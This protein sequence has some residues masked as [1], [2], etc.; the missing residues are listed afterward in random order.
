[1]STIRSSSSSMT[2]ING[3][4]QSLLD[5]Q[6]AK[7]TAQLN[8]VLSSL[9]QQDKD[10]II[11]PKLSRES[12][13]RTLMSDVQKCQNPL[14]LAVYL[15][16]IDST[17]ELI[18]NQ[19]DDSMII[20][21]RQFLGTAYIAATQPITT[22]TESR[23]T[24]ISEAQSLLAIDLN[25]RLSRLTDKERSQI[26][27][28]FSAPKVVLSNIQ[29]AESS[30]KRDQLVHTGTKNTTTAVGQKNTAL[31]PAKALSYHP[32]AIFSSQET[33]HTIRALSDTCAEYTEQIVADFKTRLSASK[34]VG[35]VAALIYFY[36]DSL[37]GQ[38]ATNNQAAIKFCQLLDNTLLQLAKTHPQIPLFMFQAQSFARLPLAARQELNTGM[39]VLPS[40][41]YQ[42]L[43]EATPAPNE[44]YHAVSTL[45]HVRKQFTDKGLTPPDML[46]QFY[47]RLVT[48]GEQAVVEKLKFYQNTASGLLDS[49]KHNVLPSIEETNL[50]ELKGD[51]VLWRA[52][53]VKY[54]QLRAA[55]FVHLTRVLKEKS[56]NPET[57]SEYWIIVAE[58]EQLAQKRDL[59]IKD[60][61]QQTNPAV[62]DYLASSQ[63]LLDTYFKFDRSAELVV[64]G[65]ANMSAAE[66]LAWTQNNLTQYQSK[67]PAP[68]EQDIKRAQQ[69]VAHLAEAQKAHDN[70]FSLRLFLGLPP[71][72]E[73][74]VR[75][76]AKDN[77]GTGL[78]FHP[79]DKFI[80]AGL[81]LNGEDSIGTEITYAKLD[82][83][84]QYEIIAMNNDGR[85][86][87]REVTSQQERGQ[88]VVKTPVVFHVDT[89]T[90][91][92]L[93]GVETSSTAVTNFADALSDDADPHSPEVKALRK[94]IANVA[95]AAEFDAKIKQAEALP[96]EEQ[97]IS[98]GMTITTPNKD[99]EQKISTLTKQKQ[100]AQ[101][102]LEHRSNK[103]LREYLDKHPDIRNLVL[104]QK[105]IYSLK[106]GTQRIEY[107]R[108]LAMQRATMTM[109]GQLA[110]KIHAPNTSNSEQSLHRLMAA[111]LMQAVQKAKQENRAVDEVLIR[112]IL[113]LP[114]PNTAYPMNLEALQ[115]LVVAHFYDALMNQQEQKPQGYN[116]AAAQDAIRGLRE[117]AT[118]KDRFPL[119]KRWDAQT[120][121]QQAGA[122]AA[123]IPKGNVVRDAQTIDRG[124]DLNV[125]ET[126]PK[127]TEAL[128]V[129]AAQ[130]DA[131]PGKPGEYDVT[132][133]G[134]VSYRA[135]EEKPGADA[136]GPVYRDPNGLGV[137][138]KS[139]I[140]DPLHETSQA[141]AQSRLALSKADRTFVAAISTLEFL[142]DFINKNP[143]DPKTSRYQMMVLELLGA[144][145]RAGA[146]HNDDGKK[147]VQELSIEI[148]GFSSELS[149]PALLVLL[150]QHVA[151]KY[152]LGFSAAKQ[153]KIDIA[154]TVNIAEQIHAKEASKDFTRIK[155]AVTARIAELEKQIEALNKKKVETQVLGIE[156]AIK[157]E[158]KL[159]ENEITSLQSRLLVIEEV[160]T[161]VQQAVDTIKQLHSRHTALVSAA[162][163][164]TDTTTKAVLFN[165]AL[166]IKENINA[167]AQKIKIQ[168][169]VAVG[170]CK[171][172]LGNEDLV[173]IREEIGKEMVQLK[174]QIAQLKS[175][176]PQDPEAI[177]KKTD[178]LKDLE[179][180]FA[181]INDVV[182]KLLIP[183]AKQIEK[184]QQQLSS[185]EE[186]LNKLKEKL[187]GLKQNKLIV[188]AEETARQQNLE[189]E[190][191]NLK[192]KIGNQEHEHD[193]KVK[194]LIAENKSFAIEED[195]PSLSA[196]ASNIALITLPVT[197]N[198]DAFVAESQTFI[199][200]EKTKLGT[201][202]RHEQAAL[203]TTE[204]AITNKAKA[205]V[206]TI[207][208]DGRVAEAGNKQIANRRALLLQLVVQSGAW[209]K[210]ENKGNNYTG[211]VQLAAVFD[212]DAARDLAK[213]LTQQE[214]DAL[215]ESLSI[216]QQAQLLAPA[217]SDVLERANIQTKIASLTEFGHQLDDHQ[218]VLGQI[219]ALRT[220]AK[221]AKEKNNNQQALLFE[222]TAQIMADAAKQAQQGSFV[223]SS[224][225]KLAELEKE[226][227]ETEAQKATAGESEKSKIE[228]Q[229]AILENKIELIK[230]NLASN[231]VYDL[232][233]VAD[234]LGVKNLT[235]IENNEQTLIT[236]LQQRYNYEARIGKTTTT[237]NQDA[238]SPTVPAA[239]LALRYFDEAQQ[240]LVQLDADANRKQP[241]TQTQLGSNISSSTESTLVEQYGEEDAG[242]LSALLSRYYAVLGLPY[243][244]GETTLPLSQ[245]ATEHKGLFLN[246]IAPK[247]APIMQYWQARGKNTNPTNNKDGWV[248]SRRNAD[249]RQ[250]LD[251]LGHPIVDNLTFQELAGWTDLLQALYPNELDG[252]SALNHLRYDLTR[253]NIKGLCSL[254]E[255]KNYLA[256]VL[257]GNF[258]T[259]QQHPELLVIFK[260]AQMVTGLDYRY[261]M[262][263]SPDL[264]WKLAQKD[265]EA[266]KLIEEKRKQ[267][268]KRVDARLITAPLKLEDIQAVRSK[269]EVLGL[270]KDQ[271][272]IDFLS[273]SVGIDQNTAEANNKDS[274]QT[275]GNRYGSFGKEQKVGSGGIS[276]NAKGKIE[277]KKTK[278][279]DDV[280][281]PR[282]AQPKE[283]PA[284]Q[285]LH[286]TLNTLKHMGPHTP[287][288]EVLGRLLA[289][290]KVG[291]VEGLLAKLKELKLDTSITLGAATSQF[292]THQ[293]QYDKMTFAQRMNAPIG[294]VLHVSGTSSVLHTLTA[295]CGLFG[296]SYKEENAVKFNVPTL[297][298][299]G[300]LFIDCNLRVVMPTSE[301]DSS[302]G[303]VNYTNPKMQQ[304]E[305]YQKA[306]QQ[307]KRRAH[308]V[309]QNVATA[310]QKL[311]IVP[312]EPVESALNAVF[313][314]LGVANLEQAQNKFAILGLTGNLLDNLRSFVSMFGF[315]S[316]NIPSALDQITKL[317]TGYELNTDQQ[318]PTVLDVARVL[319][320]KLGQ[321]TLVELGSLLAEFG[322][323]NQHGFKTSIATL[324][325]I[326]GFKTSDISNL[327]DIKEKITDV[328][329][330]VTACGGKK[331]A[332]EILKQL[333]ALGINTTGGIVSPLRAFAFS[334]IG[335]S[336]NTTLDS[337]K[338][339]ADALEK[340][341]TGIDKVQGK[342][343]DPIAKYDLIEE[344][345]KLQKLVGAIKDITTISSILRTAHTEDG[346]LALGI[347]DT[348]EIN[349]LSALEISDRFLAYLGCSLEDLAHIVDPNK[350]GIYLFTLPLSELKTKVAIAKGEAYQSVNLALKDTLKTDNKVL[351]RG[352]SSGP[353]AKCDVLKN[354]GRHWAE[355]QRDTPL[356]MASL[357]SLFKGTKDIDSSV[358]QD[359]GSIYATMH[360]FVRREINTRGELV[361]KC[362]DDKQGCEIHMKQVEAD[363][364][365]LERLLLSSPLDPQK[366]KEIAKEFNEKY[367]S[368]NSDF[369]FGKYYDPMLSAYNFAFNTADKKV[370]L[371][372]LKMDSSRNLE[373]RANFV[374]SSL[375]AVQAEFSGDINDKT[376]MAFLDT[377]EKDLVKKITDAALPN[378]DDF[379]SE[380]KSSLLVNK[381]K[382]LKE[383]ART[384]KD[385]VIKLK[386]YN[387]TGRIQKLDTLIR[388][389]EEGSKN[390]EIAI[391]IKEKAIPEEQKQEAEA[392][393]KKKEA[394][395][396]AA[397]RKK[398]AEAKAAKEKEDAESK[399]YLDLVGGVAPPKVRK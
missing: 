389:L 375:R 160:L 165:M 68:K 170:K 5:A 301:E 305:A 308:G 243:A 315:D 348:N 54:E 201:Q 138:V 334:H 291:S 254:N 176:T 330:V 179:A 88:N 288:K 251:L 14:E 222:H 215:V 349:T 147:T 335:V 270:K 74:L 292:R 51:L 210:F 116:P 342:T 260:D 265:P 10:T 378:N 91:Q 392:A 166:E 164:E 332:S 13:L 367:F 363:L 240:H 281:S 294:E 162:K 221:E 230:S 385:V 64:D 194:D 318:H 157:A 304:E 4:S 29:A 276:I 62:E 338:N 69:I 90:E 347:S 32:V 111:V 174:K 67:K 184:D 393:A 386:K 279:D 361:L 286:K 31:E 289:L 35:Q 247:I 187:N 12:F 377:V 354:A 268:L 242:R 296:T 257:S 50:P 27:S 141:I 144:L 326:T 15:Q 38:V 319:C 264:A 142:T 78:S 195:V 56:P 129:V 83:K 57:S 310:F 333:Q 350:K 53:K 266:L 228:Q 192:Q 216:E 376:K 182:E 58:I 22:A 175:T 60:F 177:Q 125:D 272:I 198:V 155:D 128:P 120:A 107:R 382:K 234:L 309:L 143:N 282:T 336:T 80:I 77:R 137:D 261:L 94:Y 110:D 178:K 20:N 355:E 290:F 396:E 44:N 325:Q 103:E 214:L 132:F 399:S 368:D 2:A 324:S 65:R 235:D 287:V 317:F 223:V 124:G 263:E 19:T 312:A 16:S 231:H 331:N 197:S 42:A 102:R 193:Q 149:V 321:Q 106:Q 70:N 105:N 186:Q 219:Q 145:E 250:F 371:V 169:D 302:I 388:D 241:A 11:V 72:P 232:P 262:D 92:D 397:E 297:E 17:F 7:I 148:A 380:M 191:A 84:K 387:Q 323:D 173:Y 25:L 140:E 167:P 359:I 298:T 93:G 238:T 181:K 395:A 26:E 274:E 150:E 86:V 284:T 229:I 52:F 299:L 358:I 109:L 123:V 119:K 39:A 285:L 23:Q 327:A 390:L 112:D 295:I 379:D 271:S 156:L 118:I 249:I 196:L 311:G 114:W 101:Y 199:G 203:Q 356:S 322:I 360:W 344:F 212:E 21:L 59:F 255:L 293:A 121:Q 96:K 95:A 246:K 3:A 209:Q 239:L 245:M 24:S 139:K 189:Q 158:I 233:S 373:I 85:F 161:N 236:F 218:Q 314:K 346:K 269:L 381:A 131:K 1:M 280:K 211:L 329:T 185:L 205:A 204:E 220:K 146:I 41:L 364:L 180:R 33:A 237:G 55:L 303:E 259:I 45:L 341:K 48:Q 135:K 76:G 87:L 82:P 151:H 273:Q 320:D 256:P 46:E 37:K 63:S 202:I 47:N 97:S 127:G 163:Q 207:E 300:K 345:C 278:F 71:R 190:I 115:K 159:R 73:L 183:T 351:L 277:V 134:P 133:R 258:E 316:K 374:L 369:S 171:T 339:I 366:I 28:K 340:A 43:N 275:N 384:L 206:S 136:R 152:Q 89:D 307:E 122:S 365:R 343:T 383:L 99:R 357:S 248:L 313:K 40:S 172:L 168:R 394:E 352:V 30:D 253:W 188:S 6:K 372:P 79:N 283:T 130:A 117:R 34:T 18:I 226:L 213:K 244:Q 8:N 208:P 227:A 61:R 267:F 337:A 36:K 108:G 328:Q 225:A 75:G 98:A 217:D 9:S 49:V 370:K 353:N 126:R 153:D 362:W 224:H 398:E 104:A 100:A 154:H 66:V 306:Q 113:Q 252:V 81:N 391:L 200:E